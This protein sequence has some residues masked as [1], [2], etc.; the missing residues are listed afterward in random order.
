M[1]VFRYMLSSNI[2][3]PDAFTF[4]QL[5][6]QCSR[7]KDDA[8]AMQVYDILKRSSIQYNL[9]S[10][11][12][13][14]SLLVKSDRFSEA[15]T[16]YDDM[17][18]R[19]VKPDSIT[20]L[21]LLNG[22]AD[23]KNYAL[24]ERFYKEIIACGI[25][26]DV[27]LA[28]P[29]IRMLIL[30]GENTEAS[31]LYQ[32]VKKQ[33][34]PNSIMFLTLLTAC[35]DAEN[36]DFGWQL[37]LDLKSS[38]IVYDIPLSNVVM[39]ILLLCGKS[40]EAITIYNTLRK[41]GSPTPITF[42]VLLTTCMVVKNFELGRKL[43]TDMH[44][45]GIIDN[46]LKIIEIVFLIRSGASTNAMDKYKKL[47][48]AMDSI[49]FITV[50]T[51]CADTEN[52]DMA[53]LVYDDLMQ[54]KLTRVHDLKLNN[55]LINMLFKCDR[56]YE[57]KQV[58]LNM[59]R[60][61]PKPDT[62]TYGSVLLGCAETGN[63]NF[64]NQVYN[65]LCKNVKM[66]DIKLRTIVLNLLVKCRKLSEAE[67]L[68][69]QYKTDADTYYYGVL[70]TA[71]GD[72][73][74]YTFGRKILSDLETSGII[75]GLTLKNITI[76]MLVKCN[77]LDEAL[78]IYKNMLQFG[79]APDNVTYTILLMA[80]ADTD[81]Y[82]LGR[83]LCSDLEK[84]G[85]TSDVKMKTVIINMHIKCGKL[86]QAL[87]M[88]EQMVQNGTQIDDIVYVTMMAACADIAALALALTLHGL[89]K[90]REL[91]SIVINNAIINMF[92]KC[93]MTDDAL[94]IF[95]NMRTEHAQMDTTTWSAMIYVCSLNRRTKQVLDLLEEMQNYG[96]R[97]D[98]QALVGVLN[99]CSDGYFTEKALEII[100]H[101]ETK[102]GVVPDT[103]L[104]NVVV[105]TL[106]R[107]GQLEKAENFI[108]KMPE[109]N[110]VTYMSLLSGC[111]KFNDDVRGER[112]SK[113]LFELAPDDTAS[114]MMSN[115]YLRNLCGMIVES[116]WQ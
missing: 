85:V 35:A 71:C 1:A 23:S 84:Q 111:K 49:S 76:N 108:A 59:V 107:A 91:D 86:E 92:G 38:G 98:S 24:G 29:V 18:E 14:I 25:P 48:M 67:K 30:F 68:H 72:T 81:N 104:C 82:D 5:L 109:A 99:A 95:S 87:E 101:M 57:A 89:I 64:G 77:Y 12:T 16:V 78:K 97:P 33:F 13:L 69:E 75:Q 31:N 44:K 40:S 3:E 113:K 46:R 60:H 42:V 52:Y 26:L 6:L 83:R 102:Y 51:A 88:E 66:L 32:R 39:R 15:M 54:S 4:G 94:K 62:I 7:A 43:C 103:Q 116:C 22:A 53:Q 41:K 45:L 19:N 27:K 80:S 100:E 58:Y 74:S 61:G 17:V 110:H 63:F 105:D 34:E 115:I 112:A 73:K 10:I 70:L 96:F 56:S 9:I 65:D 8:T 36:Y 79:P 93:G 47:D 50:M 37:Y 11:N 20:Y 2:I 90:K 28:T 106:A 55:A 114:I 21:A